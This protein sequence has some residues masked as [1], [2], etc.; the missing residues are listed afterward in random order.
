ME[1]LVISPEPF[2]QKC[3]SL[4]GAKSIYLEVVDGR[5]RLAWK[6]DDAADFMEWGDY[7]GLG[8]TYD[9]LLEALSEA[10]GATSMNGC[11]PIN[12]AIREGTSSDI[13]MRLWDSQSNTRI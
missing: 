11:Y 7:I 1:R 3:R 6:N 5:V 10:G 2:V 9:M 4:A 13:I 8:I 12:D